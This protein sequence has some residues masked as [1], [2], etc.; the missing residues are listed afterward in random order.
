MNAHSTRRIG[1]AI[2]LA[3]LSLA[4]ASA[5][6]DGFKA[7]DPGAFWPG[8]VDLTRSS[9]MGGAHSAIATGNDALLVNPAGLSQ[10][11]RYHFQLDGG[12]DSRSSGRV[13]SVS[14]VDSSSI[15]AGSGLLFQNWTSGSNPDGRASGW[16]G[17]IGYSYYTG[18]FFFGGMTKYLRFNGSYGEIRQFVQDA[19][20]LVRTG[21]FAWSAVMQN[22]STSAVPLFPLNSTIGVAWGSDS[23]WHLAVDYKTDLA[24]LDHW[25]H[26]L[27]S[28]LEIPSTAPGCSA[29][30]TAGTSPTRWARGLWAPRSSPRSSASMRHGAA[31]CR[32]RSTSS[33]SSASPSIW[34]SCV[35]A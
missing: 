22:L 25:K 13:Y 19:G 27:N 20:M 3:A 30:A 6:A 8:Q 14:V 12:F 2:C 11:K 31:G 34:S 7:D 1:A 17:G 29:A 24:D 9:G 16:L 4:G 10:T 21:D 5:R 18:N 33:S 23:D 28:G 26:R 35:R 15:S 32:A